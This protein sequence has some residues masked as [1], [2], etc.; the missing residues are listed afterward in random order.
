MYAIY[1][2]MEI[3]QGN[4]LFSYLIPKKCL[5]SKTENRKVKQVLSEGLVPVG[6]GRM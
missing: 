5:F 6:G 3:L 2:Y 4:S 1:I